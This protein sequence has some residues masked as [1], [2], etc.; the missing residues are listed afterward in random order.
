MN[1]IECDGHHLAGAETVSGDQ[2]QHR[3]VAK[4]DGRRR[5]DRSQKRLHRIPWEG[6]RQL[7]KPVKLWRV[8]LA[9]EPMRNPAV[10]SEKS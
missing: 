3:V 10:H 9:I 5:V 1:V 4:P 2:E 8:D 6:A 7:L